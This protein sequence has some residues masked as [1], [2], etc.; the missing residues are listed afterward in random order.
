MAAGPTNDYA[1]L[2]VEPIEV[3][4]GARWVPLVLGPGAAFDERIAAF[5]KQLAGEL[6][7]VLPK[8]R[9]RDTPRLAADRYEIRI[10]GVVVG[11]GE[12]R[13]DR[14]LAIHAGGER[15]S[16]LK[17]EATRDPTYGLPALWIDAAD[18]EKALAERCTLVDPSTVLMTHLTETLKR[19]APTLLTRAE[20][21]KLLARVRESQPTLVEELIPTVLGAA[22]VQRVLQG[23]LREKVSIR[24][25]EAILET[26][27]DAGRT[28]KDPSL[29]VE[30]VRQRL[31]QAICQSLLG[32]QGA[33]HVMTL[34][35]GLEGRWLGELRAA[36]AGQPL[37]LDGAGTEAW[38]G[39]LVQQAERMM[40]GNLLPV[41][42]CSP[43]LRRH[44][45]ALSERVLPHLRVVAMTEVP[46]SVEL[47]SYAVV[48]A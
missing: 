46:Q 48:A 47:K 13:G 27:A 5:R 30:R 35:P 29:L 45:R 33:L 28:V 39:R 25:L 20:T 7:F 18:R 3:H 6:G 19:E 23:L 21:E 26:L 40:R 32:E 43:D 42:L 2:A 11:R 24:H 9:F 17:G 36:E 41:L 12:S 44:V 15:A 22:D 31:G 34:D 8:V 37:L 10:D 4:V 1:A 16:A 38:L 14:L